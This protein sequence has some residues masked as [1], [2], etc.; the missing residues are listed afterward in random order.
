LGLTGPTLLAAV[1]ISG[2]PT[3]QNV[4]VFATHYRVA[5]SLARDAVVLSTVVA[6]VSL[7]LI[8]AAL[9]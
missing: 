5:Q 4:F 1:L 6:A 3:A 8:A 2:L 9:G 7:A